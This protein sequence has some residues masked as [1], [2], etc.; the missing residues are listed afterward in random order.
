MWDTE[1]A[2]KHIDAHGW[3][4]V[5][6]AI[7]DERLAAYRGT[8]DHL[9]RED[10]SVQEHLKDNPDAYYVEVLPNKHPLFE[11][12]FLNP[13]VLPIV[14]HCLGAD[15]TANELWALGTLPGGFTKEENTLP[16]RYHCDKPLCL[17]DHVLSMQL[18][19]PMIDLTK[20][21]GATRIVPG[22]HRSGHH[23]D[24]NVAHYDDEVYLEAPA[25]SCLIFVSHLWHSSSGNYTSEVRSTLWAQFQRPWI[26]PY[27]D[28][29]RALRPEVIQRA[30]PEA[31]RIY[32]LSWPV[33]FTE[34]WMW[35]IQSG[36][37]RPEYLDELSHTFGDCCLDQGH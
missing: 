7:R 16:G 8:I 20:D 14:E 24:A 34:R 19:F 12:Y 27:I 36:R 21:N 17:P 31:R 28:F 1:A 22:S 5:E 33:P 11:D 35:D 10:R 3:A 13:R 23:P 6:S 18:C 30:T 2:I 32:G 4:I 26:K 15:F 9:Y 37:P 25:G 29:G